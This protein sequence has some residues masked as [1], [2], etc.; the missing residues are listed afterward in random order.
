MAAA[1][2]KV[3][4]RALKLGDRISPTGAARG[5][6][7]GIGMR[8]VPAVTRATVHLVLDREYF[9]SRGIDAY[10][11]R[12]GRRARLVCARFCAGAN[13]RA[14]EID[15]QN[16]VSRKLVLLP[17]ERK[18]KIYFSFKSVAFLSLRYLDEYLFWVLYR[19]CA[20]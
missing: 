3:P 20:N 19:A 9:F 1:L 16:H 13:G 12:I 7:I 8:I 15:K 5:Q 4:V 17:S 11:L 6:A 2:P 10:T 14:K 18:G